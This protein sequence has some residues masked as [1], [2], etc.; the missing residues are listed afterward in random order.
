MFFLKKLLAAQNDPQDFFDWV[1]PPWYTFKALRT[2]GAVPTAAVLTLE[3]PAEH[4]EPVKSETLE[5]KTVAMP[6]YDDDEP[7]VVVALDKEKREAGDEL[8]L[9]IPS[10][11][12]SHNTINPASTAAIPLPEVPPMSPASTA[13]IPLAD[14]LPPGSNQEAQATATG[15]QPEPSRLTAQSQPPATVTKELTSQPIKFPETLGEL[16]ESLTKSDSSMVATMPDAQTITPT[17]TPAPTIEAVSKTPVAEPVSAPMPTAAPIVTPVA[18][19]G[20]AQ[21]VISRL[22]KG[23]E[24]PD[25]F[26]YLIF[27]D[28]GGLEE[29]GYTILGKSQDTKY[30][31]LVFP[32]PDLTLAVVLEKIPA[33]DQEELQTLLVQARFWESLR[34]LR[35]TFPAV[36]FRQARQ[37]LKELVRY[38]QIRLSS[39]ISFPLP[40]LASPQKKEVLQLL[41]QGKTL[42]AIYLW[43]KLTNLGLKESREQ[44]ECLCEKHSLLYDPGQSKITSTLWEKLK[45]KQS[46][47]PV[48]KIIELIVLI[49]LI[50]M[51]VS[52]GLFQ[53]LWELF[54][55]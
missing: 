45:L 54:S 47:W 40:K 48:G 41:K 46:S 5:A 23:E 12:Q 42:E 6:L 50:A 20:S 1:M 3:P 34:L 32:T 29:K 10:E 53:K 16:E 44:I 11:L 21:V 33:K 15:Q 2:G 22:Q 14:L 8:Y 26:D 51:A 31:A 39:K 24:Y 36:S 37:L 25:N 4:V 49:L 38:Y 19:E 28:Q 17:T 27:E 7:A 55:H 18:T 13:A 43:R 9:P 52:N 30:Q 35:T